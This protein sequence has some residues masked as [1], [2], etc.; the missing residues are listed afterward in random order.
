MNCNFMCITSVLQG[1]C[2]VGQGMCWLGG[3]ATKLMKKD[4]KMAYGILLMFYCAL[5]FVLLFWVSG[6][7]SFATKMIGCEGQDGSC[8]GISAVL[9]LSFV[10]A[11]LH[12]L[13][14]LSCLTRDT[15]AKIVN[16]GLWGFKML[17]VVGGF[18]GSLFIPNTFFTKYAQFSLYAGFIYLFAQAV[19]LIDGFYLWAEFWAKKYDD[20]NKCYGCLLIFVSLIMYSLSGYFVYFGFERFWNPGCGGNKAYMIITL[21]IYVLYVVF[22][23]LRFHPQGSIITSGA[24]TIFG[25]FLVWESLVSDPSESCNPEYKSKNSMVLQIVFSLLFG[26]SCNIYWALSTQ[27]SAAYQQ[28]KIQAPNVTEGDKE[29]E[30]KKEK[31]NE[32]NKGKEGQTNLIQRDDPN[33][34]AD[35][36]NNSYIKFHGFMVLFSI[37]ICPVFTNWG[38]ASISNNTWNYDNSTSAAPYYLKILVA[39]FTLLLY[40]WTIVAPK[41][42]PEREF[43]TNN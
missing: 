36:E 29:A 21:L 41:I 22:I 14:G 42:F 30:E 17:L 6:W 16:E 8:L 23:I 31:E 13:V 2:L 15:F 1:L 35:Y 40:M 3:G 34:F 12:L 7:L 18:I 5:L 27:S 19:S 28:A 26:F 10:L 43:G 4:V 33:K 32:E 24:I 11:V 9:R 25:S 37:Y 20:G 39:V 38:H